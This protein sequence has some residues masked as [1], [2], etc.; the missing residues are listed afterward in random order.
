MANLI[1][2]LRASERDQH[3]RATLARLEERQ[4]IAEDLHDDLAQLLFAAQIQLDGLLDLDQIGAE[5]RTRAEHARRLLIR[6]D[7]VIREVIGQLTEPAP[8]G[9]ASRLSDV[10]RVVREEFRL[11]AQIEITPA[12]AAA[13]RS[14]EAAVADPLVKVAREALVNVAKHAGSCRVRLTLDRTEPGELQLRVRDDGVGIDPVAMES[15]QGLG[16]LRRSVTAAGGQ[17][18]VNREASGGTTVLATFPA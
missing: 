4:R 3:Q 8:G 9:V 7:G 15:P 5:T 13:T 11:E 14:L 18:Q 17:L 1:A 16:S 6:G 12:G 2:L 10:V